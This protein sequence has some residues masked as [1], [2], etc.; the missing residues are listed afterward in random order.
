MDN[1]FLI[2]QVITSEGDIIKLALTRNGRRIDVMSIDGDIVIKK[3]GGGMNEF[4]QVDV[5]DT[6]SIIVSKS[7]K[8]KD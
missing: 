5:V 8:F 2:R 1:K 4:N 7:T 6:N 3:V